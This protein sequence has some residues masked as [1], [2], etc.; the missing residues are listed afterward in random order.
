LQSQESQSQLDIQTVSIKNTH[1]NDIPKYTIECSD[2]TLS[3]QIM[4][5]L[6]V[7]DSYVMHRE[8]MSF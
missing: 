4:N 1:K 5:E 8:E 3:T 6:Q 2:K 7:T